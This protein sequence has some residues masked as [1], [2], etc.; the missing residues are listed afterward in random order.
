[1]STIASHE[2]SW[3]GEHQPRR[4]DVDLAHAQ[5]DSFLLSNFKAILLSSPETE[6]VEQL[7]QTNLSSRVS[8]PN[9]STS[10]PPD[11]RQALNRPNFTYPVSLLSSFPNHPLKSDLA[12]LRRVYTQVCNDHSFFRRI[13]LPLVSREVVAPPLS[14]GLACLGAVHVRRPAEESR[15]LFI[16]GADLWA[17]MM[18]VDNRE[19]R[20][21][22]MIT[23]VGLNTRISY[24]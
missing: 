13:S 14:F 21:L 23:A 7:I 11:S 24:G 18:E 20:S 10:L 19:A 6:H 16:A 9:F 22:D 8:C 4:R 17:V 5:P 15:N 3:P 1:M 2:S 12:H